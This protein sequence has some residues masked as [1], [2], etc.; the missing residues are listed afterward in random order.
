LQLDIY[1]GIPICRE[2]LEDPDSL[3]FGEFH[4]VILTIYYDE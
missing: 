1:E 3:Y 2:V 4:C